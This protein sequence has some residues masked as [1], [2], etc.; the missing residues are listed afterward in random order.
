MNRFVSAGRAANR[1]R[2]TDIALFGSDAIVLPFAKCRAD[3]MNRRE[4]ENVESHSGDARQLLF[5]VAQ[6]ADGS[7]KHFVPRTELGTLAIDFDH[8]LD[9]ILRREFAIAVAPHQF[10]EIG[11]LQIFDALRVRE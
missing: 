4:I 8:H 1:P 2:R 7:G 5:D 6:C 11:A 3:R 9:R 10:N